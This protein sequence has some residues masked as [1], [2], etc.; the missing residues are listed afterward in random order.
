MFIK[1]LKVMNLVC[2]FFISSTHM[3]QCGENFF[4]CNATSKSLSP[5]PSLYPSIPP[6]L[7]PSLPSIIHPSLLVFCADSLPLH[8]ATLALP[9]HFRKADLYQEG[10]GEGQRTLKRQGSLKRSLSLKWVHSTFLCHL[11]YEPTTLLCIDLRIRM[12]N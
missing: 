10:D 7:H 6:S 4:D 9:Y 3:K 5:P 2:I 11:V 8:E 12:H 1:V